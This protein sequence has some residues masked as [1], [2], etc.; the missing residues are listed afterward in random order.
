MLAFLALLGDAT[1]VDVSWL[2]INDLQTG[3]TRTLY[4][5]NKR[6]TSMAYRHRIYP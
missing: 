1:I 3:N 6:L 4:P 5:K 2:R